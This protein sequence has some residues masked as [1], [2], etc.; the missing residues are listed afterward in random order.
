MPEAESAD[1]C[2]GQK[3]DTSGFWHRGNGTVGPH[4][5]PGSIDRLT[6]ITAP[7]R[8]VATIGHTALI[9]VAIDPVQI[10]GAN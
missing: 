8:I 3:E 9:K 5:A 6:D 10:R 7:Q 4:D 1:C 2:C